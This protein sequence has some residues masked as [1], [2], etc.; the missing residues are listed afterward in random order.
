MLSPAKAITAGAIVFAI[1]G[2][3]LIAQLFEQQGTVPGAAVD[4]CTN[5]VVPVTGTIIWG[6]EGPDTQRYL[7]DSGEHIRNFVFTSTMSLSDDRLDGST[8]ATGDHDQ[9]ED[10]GFYR[11]TRVIENT[12]GTWEGPETLVGSIRAGEGFYSM[13]DLTGTGSY[14]GLSAVLFI[15]N[16]IHTASPTISGSIYPTDLASC[17]FSTRN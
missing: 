16:N 2:A 11:G 10:G 14:D 8:T 15:E 6:S 17:D 9:N 12:D 3:F 4:P 5:P 13:S 7:T 1:G